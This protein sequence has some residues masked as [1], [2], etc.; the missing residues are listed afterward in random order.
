MSFTACSR[1]C[2]AFRGSQLVRLTALSKPVRLVTAQRTKFQKPDIH[3]FLRED[4]PGLGERGEITLV[5]LAQA[6]NYLVPFGLAYYV[7]RIKGKPIL[8]EG[9]E[10]RVRDENMEL[11]TIEPAFSTVTVE[12]RQM[13]TSA[14]STTRT[15][16]LIPDK[17]KILTTISLLTF[18]RVRVSADTSRIYGSVSAEDVA[19]ALFDKHALSVER[20]MIQFPADTPRIKDVGDYDVL[21]ELGGGMKAHQLKVVVQE[22]K[23]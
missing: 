4:V 21:I 11:E 9:W 22:P 8:P 20:D 7:P 5:N 6:R 2:V 10:P 3:V 17:Q 19:K 13:T 18:D 1:H 14:S 15:A 23:L 16:D 12:T